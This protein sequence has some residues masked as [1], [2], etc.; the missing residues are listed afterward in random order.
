[1]LEQ[2][3]SSLTSCCFNL[4]NSGAASRGNSSEAGSVHAPEA[5]GGG[6][7]Q[8]A[9]DAGGRGGEQEER[10]EASFHP[11]GSGLYKAFR[12]GDHQE[13]NLVSKNSTVQLYH[14]LSIFT[15]FHL[16]LADMKKKVEQEASLLEGAEENRKK[17]QRE[18]DNLMLQLEEKT[19][20]YDKLDKTKTRL[21]QELD[22]LLVDQHNLRQVV[23][24]LE[25]KQK[26]FDQVTLCS[27]L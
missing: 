8:P 12:A 15:P 27:K 24:N 22:D 13:L 7:E 2:C 21:Q 10:G 4:L 19:A 26:K 18:L 25:R 20:T 14:F 11:A 6:A 5:A 9:G 3:S 16:Q 17:A 23:S 1:M